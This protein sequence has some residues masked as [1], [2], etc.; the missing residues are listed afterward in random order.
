LSLLV[1]EN[2]TKDFGGFRALDNVC[3]QV[4]AGEKRALIGP[5]GAGKSTLLNIITGKYKPTAGRIHLQGEDITGLATHKIADK[6]ITRSFQIT[7]IFPSMTVFENIRN[8]MISKHKMRY[9]ITSRLTKVSVIR[10]DTEEHMEFMG[11]ADRRDTPV[12]TLSYGEQRE[13]EIALTLALKPK[14][15]LLDEPT[16]G[17]NKQETL[18][19]IKLIRRVAVDKPLIIVEHDMSVVFDLAQSISVLYYGAVL[20]TGSKDDIRNSQKVKKAYLGEN[21]HAA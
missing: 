16:A 15:I 2:L 10:R 13:I 6:G 1:I 7:N 20:E 21:L 4:A 3:M 12:A 11:L 18:K 8:A 9:K 19:I 14:L 17:L 5:N